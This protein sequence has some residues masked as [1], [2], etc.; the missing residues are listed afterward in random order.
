MQ[1]VAH[2]PI[3]ARPV[4]SVAGSVVAAHA[5]RV[6]GGMPADSAEAHGA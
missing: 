5:A 1:K 6:S 4:V 3:P 2:H